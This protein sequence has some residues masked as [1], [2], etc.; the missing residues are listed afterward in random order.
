[1]IA[2]QRQISDDLERMKHISLEINT[3][4]IMVL[5][6]FYERLSLLPYDV[7][8]SSERIEAIMLDFTLSQHMDTEEHDSAVLKYV[9][10]DQD[11]LS[12][13]ELQKAVKHKIM[14]F[15]LYYIK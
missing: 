4:P 3:K 12:L 13:E 11:L 15:W 6:S 10:L 2:E 5:Y 9:T 8:H 7:L 14:K 1:M